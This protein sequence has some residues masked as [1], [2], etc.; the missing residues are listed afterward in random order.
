MTLHFL[1]ILACAVLSMALGFIWYGPLFGRT[2]M[3]I[4]GADA[5]DLERRKEM[6]KRAMP[7]YLVQ[8]LLTM[9]QMWVLSFFV[10]TIEMTQS[11]GGGHTAFGIWIAFIMPTV[12]ASAMWTAEAGKAKWTRFA[13]QA[14]YQLVLFIACGYIL[15]MWR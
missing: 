14:G 5:A 3:R 15:G 12:A 13:L 1:P 8:F 9:F 6:Q 11:V 10:G 7:L 4:T 2:W